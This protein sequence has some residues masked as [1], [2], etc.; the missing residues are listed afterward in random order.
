MDFLFKK[1]EQIWINIDIPTKK[2][3]VHHKCTYTE[4]M[5]ET[6]FKGIG[7]LKRDGGWLKVDSLKAAEQLFEEK[8]SHFS[9]VNHCSQGT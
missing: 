8:Y 9:F 2:I 7:T 3:T 1:K 4:K 6:S 5:K